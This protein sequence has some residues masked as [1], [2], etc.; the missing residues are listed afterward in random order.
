M[1]RQPFCIKMIKIKQLTVKV[2]WRCNLLKSAE[3]NN[4]TITTITIITTTTTPTT[5]ISTT[6]TTIM[7]AIMTHHHNHNQDLLSISVKMTNFSESLQVRPG[8]QK[9]TLEECSSRTYYKSVAFSATQAA[10]SSAT[11]DITTQ[12]YLNH[13]ESSCIW[14]TLHGL[15]AHTT[16][17]ANLI[18]SSIT[19]KHLWTDIKRCANMSSQT[20]CCGCI[21]SNTFTLACRIWSI[22]CQLC[23][24]CLSVHI[25][26]PSVSNMY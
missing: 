2:D 10:L 5:T 4:S 22:Q 15:T 11:N 16:I 19:V 3:P 21:T 20:S 25:I 9:W 8:L 18:I 13:N 24:S 23:Q 12:I 6:M 14:R 1:G 17:T 26:P 7:T